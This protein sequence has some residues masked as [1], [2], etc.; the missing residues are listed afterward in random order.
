MDTSLKDVNSIVAELMAHHGV[1]HVNLHY[2]S[3]S[4]LLWLY[5]D[6]HQYRLHVL[7][8][9]INPAVCLAYPRR[10]Y[11]EKA[12]LSADKI[13]QVLETFSSLRLVDETVYLRSASL[14]IINGQVGLTFSCDGSHY[15]DVE[16]FLQQPERFSINTIT[17]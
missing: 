2:G 14:N 6:P 4:A 3:S 9:I 5:D 1:F 16:D 17:D 11:P 10:S 15:L 8:E 12:K 13:H 7:D